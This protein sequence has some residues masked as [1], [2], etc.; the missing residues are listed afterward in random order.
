MHVYSNGDVIPAG[1]DEHCSAHCYLRAGVDPP[2]ELV[3]DCP[4][5]VS[6]VEEMQE[7]T[8]RLALDSSNKKSKKQIWNKVRKIAD[9]FIEAN[10]PYH[11]LDERQVN[12]RYVL[13][14][15]FIVCFLY[16]SNFLYQI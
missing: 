11:G 6:I 9:P 4:K 8:D 14:R 5:M 2:S 7:M 1:E 3:K 13:I 12:N 16:T 10:T 15:T